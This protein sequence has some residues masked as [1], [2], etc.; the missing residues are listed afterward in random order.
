MLKLLK[1]ITKIVGGA[2]LYIGGL[3]QCQ[4]APTVIACCSWFGISMVGLVVMC[5]GILDYALD[6]TETKLSMAA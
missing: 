3:I 6:Y 1:K 4:V 5:Q 2:T